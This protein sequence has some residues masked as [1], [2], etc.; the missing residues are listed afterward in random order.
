DVSRVWLSDLAHVLLPYHIEQD[1]AAERARGDAALGTTGNG[2]GPAYVD[3]VAR[4]GMR[5]GDLRD[6]ARVRAIVE[7]RCAE[8]AREGIGADAAA[9][10]ARIEEHGPMVV[11]HIRDT[12][13]L[14]HDALR[15]GKR[16]IAEGAQGALLDVT[17]GTYPYVTSSSTVAGGAGAGLG[18]GPTAVEHVIGVAKAYAT[19]VGAGPFP[20]EL[21]DDVGERMRERGAEYGTVTGRARRTGWIDTVALRYVAAVNGL[22]HLA[23]T[24]LDVLDGFDQVCM[25]TGYD[26]APDASLPFQMSAPVKPVLRRFAGWTQPTTGARAYGELPPQARAYLDALAADVGVPIS[27]V[28]VGPERSQI[29]VR[30]DAPAKALASRA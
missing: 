9:I 23:I 10:V 2:I 11:P 4:R 17:F 27:Y 26:G 25:C 24:K 15:A 28:S 13:A 12:V 3:R 5:A 16:V 18:F 6:R 20:S 30:E 22:T 29:I 8:L 21:L 19:R 1:R 14:L 7:R